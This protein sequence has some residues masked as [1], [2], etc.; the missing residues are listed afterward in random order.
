MP[1][2]SRNIPTCNQVNLE[3][4]WQLFCRH[5]DLLLESEQIIF[6]SADYFFC[7][8]SFANC[9]WPYINGDGQLVLGY[10]LLRNLLLYR[11]Q[12]TKN[13]LIIR[14]TKLNF[15]ENLLWKSMLGMYSSPNFLE[16]GD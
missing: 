12:F 15:G 13:P 7:N 6:N 11:L 5:L 2:V 9:C 14:A 4:D 8:L 10:L 16:E 1:L 3:K